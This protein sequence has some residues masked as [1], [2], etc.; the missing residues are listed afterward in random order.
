MYLM[1]SDRE[2]KRLRLKTNLDDVR[3]QARWAGITEGMRVLDVGCGS[4]A[5]TEAL[6]EL[7][8]PTGAVV[9]IDFSAQRLADAKQE[10]ALPWVDFALH[11]I[12]EP[13]LA[14][15]PFDAVWSRFFLEYFRAEQLE[16]IRN[17][18]ASLRPG[19]IVC[20]GDLDHNCLNHYGHN[21]KIQQTLVDVMVHLENEHNFDPYAGRR[22]YHHLYTLGFQEIACT[23]EA[24]H[25]IYGDANDV[26]LYNWITKIE[27]AASRSGCTFSAYEGGYE[28]FRDDVRAFFKDPARF[29]YTP[30]I[31][32]RGIKQ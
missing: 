10:S 14:E 18:V 23:L 27:V 21:A 11:D 13:Y 1:E 24:H 26:D 28:A 4:G 29:I 15:Q 22:L 17:S 31:I 30:L 6:G 9:G 7:V 3:R 20:L 32:V 16:V 5:A 8:G 12:K 2:A 25:L 19:G